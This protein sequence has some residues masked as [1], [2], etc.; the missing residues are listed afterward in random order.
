MIITRS[1]AAY[2]YVS[3]DQAKEAQDNNRL[4]PSY[5]PEAEV[6]GDVYRLHDIIP[7]AE[8]KAISTSALTAAESNKDRIA[9][10]PYS[11]S[12]WINQHLNIL[13][14]AGVLNKKAV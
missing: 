4:I 13:F 5:N 1:M 14:A 3:T 2:Q 6:P 10:L 9:L 8:W 12:S 7:E 11:R